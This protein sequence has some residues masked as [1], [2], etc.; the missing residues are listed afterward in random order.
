MTDPVIL[1]DEGAKAAASPVNQMNGAG[2][3][4]YVRFKGEVKKYKVKNHRGVACISFHK[5]MVPISKL[6]GLVEHA[7]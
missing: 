7:H 4:Q 6:K 3:C 5:T 2:K 1:A